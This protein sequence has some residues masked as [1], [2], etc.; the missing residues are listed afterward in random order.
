[1]NHGSGGGGESSWSH[2][3]Q[4]KL[5]IISHN[6]VLTRCKMHIHSLLKTLCSKMFYRKY[7]KFVFTPDFCLQLTVGGEGGK[8]N[9]LTSRST[10]N[11]PGNSM[12]HACPI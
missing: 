9:S 6:S 10:R 4:N 2:Y 12:F 5:N 11:C 3:A 1:V 8:K 7:R